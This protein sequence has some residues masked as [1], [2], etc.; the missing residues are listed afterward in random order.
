MPADVLVGASFCIWL[1]HV[2]QNSTPTKTQLHSALGSMMNWK[3]FFIT[4][5]FANVVYAK[6]EIIVF[7]G[8]KISY[9][10]ESFEDQQ[11]FICPDAKDGEECIP[12][13]SM[14]FAKYKI[15]QIVKGKYKENELAYYQFDHYGL[16]EYFK[17]KY[18]L[19]VVDVTD[20]G[21]FGHKYT[22]I[23]VYRSVKGEFYYCPSPRESFAFEDYAKK[24]KFNPPVSIDT[25]HY[26]SHGIKDI[27]SSK[28]YKFENGSL[29]CV[30]GISLRHMT[31]YILE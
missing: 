19:I 14:Y 8:E 26:S 15:K 4:I 2:T 23:P 30:M 3:L 25:A 11:K 31:D 29:N 27:D 7:V 28:F 1:C 24:V 13:D 10:S 20:T 6:K 22:N 21:V 18:A 12:M 9:E 5:L 16:P 17:Y